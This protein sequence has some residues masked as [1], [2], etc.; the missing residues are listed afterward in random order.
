[1]RVRA[2]AGGDAE[3]IAAIYAPIVRDTT[4]SFEVEPPTADV[5]RARIEAHPTLPWLVAVDDADDAAILGYANARPH[6]ERAAYRWSVDTAVY[7]R[8][9]CHRRGIGK[10]LYTRLFADL[11]SRGYFQAFAGIALPNASSVGMHEAL[12]F[13]L[14]GVY[15]NVGFKL[16]A[17]RDVG[18]WQRPLQPL[19][20]PEE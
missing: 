8:T 7:V 15:E 11:V 13:K 9:D 6:R 14:V 4:I 16:G 18:W 19:R 5:M 2:A 1:M 3:Q 10:S 12:G 20:T 17:W